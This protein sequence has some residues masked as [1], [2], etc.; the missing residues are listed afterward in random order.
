[1][2]RPK[3]TLAW[4]LLTNNYR[5]SR[6]GPLPEASASPTAPETEPELDPAEALLREDLARWSMAFSSG[7]DFFDEIDGLDDRTRPASCLPLGPHGQG[8]GRGTWPAGCPIPMMTARCLGPG[9]SLE[10]RRGRSRTR[11]R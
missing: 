8:W 10:I 3:K 4:H 5:P 11:R 2:A 7:Y 6:H 1:M 9:R